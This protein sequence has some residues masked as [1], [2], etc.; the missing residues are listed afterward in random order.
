MD[1]KKFFE[2]N[3][4][5]LKYFLIIYIIVQLVSRAFFTDFY[6]NLAFEGTSNSSIFINLVYWIIKPFSSVLYPLFVSFLYSANF[7]MQI[8]SSVLDLLDLAWI[9]V[10]ASFIY[11]RLKK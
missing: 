10:I 11:S 4:N 1:W 2:P 3:W 7:L 8:I 6:T 5:K 9:Y